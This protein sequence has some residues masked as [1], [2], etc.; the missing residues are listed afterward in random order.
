MLHLVVNTF[1]SRMNMMEIVKS[2]KKPKHKEIYDHI[3][4]KIESGAF[5]PGSKIPTENELAD[6]F[7]AS[8]PT[9]S[10]A[11]RDLETRG[12]IN[13]VQ[14]SG[15]YIPDHLI[16]ENLTL[17]LLASKEALSANHN[18]GFSIFSQIIPEISTFSSQQNMALILGS[19]PYIEQST[20][21]SEAFKSCEE[22]IQRG[23][24]GVF[25]LPFEATDETM[26]VNAVIAEKFSK[27]D[28]R[29]VL[30]DRD[31]TDDP[32]KRSEYDIIGLDNTRG[33]YVL[34]RHLIDHGCKNILFLSEGS[35]NSVIQDRYF[36]YQKALWDNHL[37]GSFMPT[38]EMLQ[39]PEN[40]KADLLS[41]KTDAIVCCN[42]S[43][44]SAAMKIFSE[45]N[46][47]VP[48]DIK[49]VGFDDVP[50]AAHL[51]PSLTTIHQPVS[52]LAREAVRAMINR[53]ECPKSEARD[54]KI[55]S[56]LI[57]R[58]SCGCKD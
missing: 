7:S 18:R 28:V 27:A 17:G 53:I 35:H 9:V 43:I 56:E 21:S 48:E 57:I 58:R 42:D 2:P 22:F 40:F 37:Q 45:V 15:S 51:T 23:V 13:R 33:S 11:L 12:L 52:S 29:V 47:N 8:R 14:G 10:K 46:I 4:R 49:I 41:K 36:G 54:I 16:K 19:S 20:F 30:L 1:Y 26:G 5:K 44:A 38:S 31:I 25:F 32:T 3:Y 24:K 34:T 55:H 39:S 6:A 50:L